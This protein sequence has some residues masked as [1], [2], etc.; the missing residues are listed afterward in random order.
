[1][2]HLK[3]YEGKTLTMKDGGRVGIFWRLKQTFQE[4]RNS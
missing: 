3:T 4:V 1:M 2:R